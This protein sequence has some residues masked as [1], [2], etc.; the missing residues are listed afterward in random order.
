MLKVTVLEAPGAIETFWKPRSCFGGEAGADDG[1]PMY[2]WAT[3]APV[4][5]P[6]FVTFAV[7]VATVSYRPEAPPGAGALLPAVLSV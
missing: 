3:S 2:S 1:R 5:V 4:T 6:L 7:T